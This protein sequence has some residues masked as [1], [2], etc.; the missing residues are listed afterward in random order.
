MNPAV[1]TEVH[2]RFMEKERGAL[3][4]EVNPPLAAMETYRRESIALLQDLSRENLKRLTALMEDFCHSVEQFE[5]N[6]TEE[7]R[8]PYVELGKG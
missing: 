2:L 7:T 5:Q 3:R 6:T 8:H 4:A 1:D